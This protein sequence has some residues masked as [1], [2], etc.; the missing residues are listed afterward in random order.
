MGLRQ[1]YNVMLNILEL[2]RVSEKQFFVAID[3]GESYT[4]E[5]MIPDVIREMIR[6]RLSLGHE[7]FGKAWNE[8]EPEK[9]MKR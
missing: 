8:V 9:R 6:L 7:L 5:K 2:Y 4:D 1:Y 3:K